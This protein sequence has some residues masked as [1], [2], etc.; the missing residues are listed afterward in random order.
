MRILIVIFL[1]LAN[2]LIWAWGQGHLQAVGWPAPGVLTS[3][4]APS[5]P[6]IATPSEPNATVP[7][8]EVPVDPLS[9]ITANTVL[10]AGC[11][12]ARFWAESAEVTLR[13]VLARAPDSIF[14]RLL[15]SQLEP[16]WVV[17]IQS[18]ASTK[19]LKERLR[20]AGLDYRETEPPLPTGLIVGTF[21]NVDGAESAL[22]ELRSRGEKGFEVRQARSEI[23]VWEIAIY[24]PDAQTRDA[25]LEQLNEVPRYSDAE[26]RLADCADTKE[27]A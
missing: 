9:N 7:E 21:S 22:A 3:A 14:W 13:D 27:P 17:L 20:R 8:S 15:P 6:L 11:W 18:N 5:E 25:L 4:P 23:P 2:G 26:L 12:Q 1:F 10:P 16:R 19:D 24:A